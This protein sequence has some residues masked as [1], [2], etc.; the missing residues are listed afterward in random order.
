MI[1]K[2]LLKGMEINMGVCP[3][4]NFDDIMLIYC[5]GYNLYIY[6]AFD[7]FYATPLTIN[8]LKKMICFIVYSIM[9]WQT[10]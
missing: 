9:D 7:F 6:G 3:C 1:A 5:L 4:L 8:Y 10:K 2:G